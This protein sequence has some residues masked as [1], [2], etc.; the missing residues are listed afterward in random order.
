MHCTIYKCNRHSIAPNQSDSAVLL[1]SPPK[2]STLFVF[3]DKPACR[4]HGVLFGIHA[5]DVL[6]WT[7]ITPTRGH[8]ITNLF[9]ATTAQCATYPSIASNP[10]IILAIL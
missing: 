3:F 1:K 8:H 10:I 2:S 5:V 9:T 7:A 4:S 6:L